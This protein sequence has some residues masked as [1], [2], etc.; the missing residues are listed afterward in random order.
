[1]FCFRPQNTRKHRVKRSH[2][3]IFSLTG[4]HNRRNTIFHFARSFVG[5]GQ[6]Q[7]IKRIYALTHQIRNSNS[8]HSR[9][10]RTCTRNDNH[11]AVL[12]KYGFALRFV[13]LIN[14]VLHLEIKL[15]I[16]KIRISNVLM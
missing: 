6:R 5:K 12:L 10:T 9:F 14:I 4:S 7:N 2:P 15:W 13:Q 11:R 3:K 8:Q 1:M 16:A